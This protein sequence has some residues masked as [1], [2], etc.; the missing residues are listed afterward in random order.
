VADAQSPDGQSE[1]PRSGQAEGQDHGESEGTAV[2]KDA[3]QT[4]DARLPWYRVVAAAVLLLV[5]IGLVLWLFM[6]PPDSLA[7]KASLVVAAAVAF[8]AGVVCLPLGLRHRL[9]TFAIVAGTFAGVMAAILA[10]P[11]GA[12]LPSGSD[13][14]NGRPS[15]SSPPSRHRANLTHSH[16]LSI[17]MP[18]HIARDL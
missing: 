13:E 4:K 6:R 10:I 18:P 3:V 11:G 14:S 16:G 8:G 7:A 12:A 15:Q 2:K 9:G 17:L 5:A 1:V